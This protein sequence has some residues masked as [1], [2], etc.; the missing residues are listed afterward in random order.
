MT[1]KKKAE[2]ATR[3][4]FKM[5]PIA[6]LM[7][8]HRL[9]ER[10]LA[11]VKEELGRITAKNRADIIFIDTAVDFIRTYAD[12]THHG[13]EED[14]LFRDLSLKKISDEHKKITQELINDHI[15]ARG[16]VAKVVAAKERYANGDNEALKEIVERLREL[17]E[18]Y[19]RHIAKEDRHFF[20][21]V[22]EYFSR[23]EQD[24]MLDEMWEFD[25]KMIHE[26]YT[27]LVEKFEAG[28]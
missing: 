14:I 3:P 20:G 18:F 23:E 19:P 27:R 28:A 10:M 6:P 12:R 17:T 15:Y 1:D 22:M 13:K 26:K 4:G 2:G 25:R 24:A 8:E 11:V 9:I 16:V 7:I 21:P 5:K